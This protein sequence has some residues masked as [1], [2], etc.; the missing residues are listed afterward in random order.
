MEYKK[1]EAMLEQHSTTAKI[2]SIESSIDFSISNE[3]EE[4]KEASDTPPPSFH[5]FCRICFWWLAL[6]VMAGVWFV[7]HLKKRCR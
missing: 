4:K 3:P 5:L 7:F 6:P 2:S 1:R